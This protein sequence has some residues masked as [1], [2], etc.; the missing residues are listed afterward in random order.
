MGI[1]Y[2]DA[3]PKQPELKPHQEPLEP[4]PAPSPVPAKYHTTAAADAQRAIETAAEKVF[5]GVPEDIAIEAVR[6][7]LLYPGFSP[8]SAEATFATFRDEV[9]EEKK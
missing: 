4:A 7:S 2:R 3:R 8:A 1:R 9:E 5:A 6:R